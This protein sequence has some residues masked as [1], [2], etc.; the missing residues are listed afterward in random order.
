V[1]VIFANKK[2]IM[3]LSK[4]VKTETATII[5]VREPFEFNYGHN[6]GAINIPLNQVPLKIQDIAKLSKPLLLVCRSGNRSGMAVAMLKA[7]G[8]EEVYNAGSIE[9]I[10]RAK[11]QTA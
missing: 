2:R 11:L 6:E 3:N 7:K 10:E 9:D 5:D 1:V 4:L 8:V